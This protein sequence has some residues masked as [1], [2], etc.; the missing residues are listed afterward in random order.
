MAAKLKKKY[1]IDAPREYLIQVLI[2]VSAHINPVCGFTVCKGTQDVHKAQSMCDVKG[3]TEKRD[4]KKKKSMSE[5]ICLVCERRR[6][7]GC[8]VHLMQG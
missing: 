3:R 8:A 5:R 6:R 1:R 4:K 7:R 2:K